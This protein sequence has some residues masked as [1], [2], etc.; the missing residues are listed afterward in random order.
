MPEVAVPDSLSEDEPGHKEDCG[1]AEDVGG[2]SE[3]FHRGV[4][5]D[6]SWASFIDLLALSS[7]VAEGDS[8][9]VDV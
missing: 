8:G 4:R 6:E 3:V 9:H 5:S 7:R 2:E 1:N